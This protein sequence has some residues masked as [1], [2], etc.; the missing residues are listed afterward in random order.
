M[1]AKFVFGLI[2][3]ALF[4][5]AL[6]LGITFAAKAPSGTAQ[7]NGEEPPGLLPSNPFYFFKEWRRG[8]RRLL[9][10]DPAAKLELE[11]KIVSEKADELSKIMDIAPDS[12]SAVKKALLNYKAAQERL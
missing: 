12:V 9:T 11:I 3:I 7:L 6:P 4:L 10:S 8:I 2:F 1:R 5:T